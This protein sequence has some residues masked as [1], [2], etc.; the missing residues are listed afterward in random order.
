MPRSTPSF[1][2]VRARREPRQQRALYTRALMFEAAMRL[3]ESE[4]L[5]GFTTNRLAELSG[6]AVGTIYQYFGNKHE[7]LTALARHE[8]DTA[9]EAARRRTQAPA[10]DAQARAHTAIRSLLGLFGG[11]MKARRELLVAALTSGNSEALERP[12]L[13]L[14]AL[15]EERR[16]TV[17]A[18]GTHRLDQH[19]AYVLAN[20]V[21][22]PIRA[23]LLSDPRRLHSAAFQNALTRLIVGFFMQPCAGAEVKAGSIP[24][25]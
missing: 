16:Y 17:G 25:A 4:G 20:A 11:R 8:I 12:I 3:L 19:E 2:Q 22:G 10:G 9:L 7:L 24:K 13:A 15:L 5:A 14:A 21:L 18:R 6:F 23:A 1:K